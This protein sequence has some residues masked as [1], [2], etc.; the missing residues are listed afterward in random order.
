M[1]KR[2]AIALGIVL[3]AAT[4]CSGGD[5]G[6]GE[7]QPPPQDTLRRASTAM[8]DLRSVAFTLS[9]E[10]DPGVPVRSGDVRLLRNGDA[11]GTLNLQ[12]S[13]QAVEMKIVALGE[14]FYVKGVTGGWQ[15]YPKQLAA[16]MYD[17]SAVL[18]PNRGISRLLSSVA[19][20][21][22][23]KTEKVN[24]KDAYK[25]RG[26]LPK[27]VV[28]G[29]IPGLKGDVKG[30]VWVGTADHRLLKV[31]GDVNGGSVTVTF[32]EFDKPYKISAPA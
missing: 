9:T 8:R 3:V 23:E 30:H 22:A 14:T 6:G 12:Q 31:K 32:T 21:E 27:D 28:A 4:A 10:G 2:G 1:V 15:R 16:A 13:G 25:V 11:E 19:Q 29:L 26:T 5:D 7:K 24:G 20:P 17:P 18:D